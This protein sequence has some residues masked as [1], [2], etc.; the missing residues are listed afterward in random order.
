MGHP[1]KESTAYDKQLVALGRVLQTLREEE[2]AEV[3]IDTVLNYLQSEFDYQLIWL[4]LYDRLDHRLFGKGGITPTGDIN[5]L[6][7][8]FPLTSGDLLEQVVI[9]QRPIGVPDL[10]EEL[11]AGEWR[12]AAQKFNI[13]G[14]VIFP[15]RYKDLCFGVVLMG[16]LLWGVSPRADEKARLTMVLGSLA[17]SLHQ[18][19]QD[20]QRQQ[21]KRPDQPMFSLLSRMRSLD[22]LGARLETVVEETH[23]FVAPTRTNIYWFERER[24]YF[25]RRVSNHQKAAGFGEANQ[26][27]SGITVQE[28]NSFYQALLADQVVS[29]GEAHSSLKADTTSRLMQQI[30]SRSLL[31]AP[32]L[33]NGELLGFLAV[34][35]SEARIWEEEEKN[36][37]KAAAQLIA[38]TAPLHETEE[39]IRQTKLDQTLTAEVARAIYSDEDWRTTLKNCSDNLCKRLQVERLI[40]LLYDKDQQQFEICYQSQPANR[41][42]LP[43]PLE[44]L[45][46]SDWDMI[47]RSGSAISIENLDDDLRLVAWQTLLLEAGVRSLVV[48]NVKIGQP[49]EGVVLVCHEATRSWSHTEQELVQ[50]V[51][52]QIGLM[53]HQWQLQR[54]NEQH[55]KIYQTIQWGITTIQQTHQIERLERSA[56][57]HI[58]QVLQ[59]PLAALVTWLPGRQAGRIITPTTLSEQFALNP[60]IVVP[61]HTDGLIQWALQS[62]GLLQLGMHDLTAETRQWLNGA[63]IGQILVMALRTAPEH[64]PSGIVLVADGFGRTW[65]ERHLSAFGTLVSQLAWSRR[66]LMLTNLLQTQREELERLNWYKHRRLEEVYRSLG[67]HLRQLNDLGNQKDQLLGTR[68][69]QILRQISDSVSSLTQLLRDEQWRLRTYH[70]SVPLVGLLKRSLERVDGLLKQRQIWSQVHNEGN[71]TIG[72]DTTKIELIIYELLVAACQRA[73]TG[74]RIDLWC[75]QIDNRWLE[76]SIT[77]NGIIEPRLLSDLQV[78]RS[79]DLLAPSTLDQPPGLHLF[80]CQ[81]IMQQIGGELNLY[82]LEDGRVLSRLILPIATG[83]PIYD[84]PPRIK[85][86]ESGPF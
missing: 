39:T 45:N 22:N 71:L 60:E 66:Y 44:N 55:Q 69:Q 85:P 3:L 26:P 8:R 80:I 41:R 4:G 54:Q 30:R 7:Q 35:G 51:S 47:E 40:V 79:G 65:L 86:E 46:Q 48:C 50:V 5:F 67:W 68:Y 72:G 34:E 57:Q 16:S 58:A 33:F 10:R 9:Q 70:T 11:R 13:Q 1:Q 59:V 75:R 17:T 62:D 53:L 28:V 77:D 37:V 82:K 84:R 36:F 78:G 2:N 74:G 49:L 19:E 63:G 29:I 12:K 38:L 64:E 42:P 27:S 31:A 43:S 25:W 81:V 15:I 73:Q 61:V 6:K 23:Q 21:I 52:Q 76:L 20:W 18:I 24:R 14:T 32:I 56:L 83:N